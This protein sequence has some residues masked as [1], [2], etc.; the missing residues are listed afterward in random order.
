MKLNILMVY[1]KKLLLI[2][3]ICGRKK[4][5]KNTAQLRT[6]FFFEYKIKTALPQ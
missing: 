5:K 3:K 2:L 4:T 6:V 1:F